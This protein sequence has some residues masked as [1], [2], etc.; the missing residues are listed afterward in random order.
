MKVG[1]QNFWL[2]LLLMIPYDCLQARPSTHSF[3]VCLALPIRH[4]AVVVA[5]WEW[6]Q[7]DCGALMEL[8]AS[9]AVVV[10]LWE[11]AVSFGERRGSSTIE[12]VPQAVTVFYVVKSLCGQQLGR[13]SPLNLEPLPPLSPRS[14]LRSLLPQLLASAPSPPVGHR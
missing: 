3:P 8:A 2:V 14:I 7:V 6:R 13:S 5:F 9:G 11:E 1:S 12:G 10:L 4:A